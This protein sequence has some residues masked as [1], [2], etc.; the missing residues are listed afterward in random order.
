[1][2]RVRRTIQ[3]CG[4]SRSLAREPRPGRSGRPTRAPSHF[5]S[6]EAGANS[7]ADC[8]APAVRGT[9][10]VSARVPMPGEPAGG[11]ARAC[12]G[13]GRGRAWA[14]PAGAPLLGLRLVDRGI[15]LR[16]PSPAAPPG[17]RGPGPGGT[18]RV[19][20]G[21]GGR[22]AADESCWQRLPGL[23]AVRPTPKHW[24]PP[25]C[26]QRLTLAQCWRPFRAPHHSC[27]RLGRRRR[28]AG[29]LAPP[30]S[31][32]A[33]RRARALRERRRLWTRFHRPRARAG[34]LRFVRR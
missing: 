26:V 7:P 33:A 2:D 20:A 23:D 5:L 25:R 14:G 4:F 34:I 13:R 11:G 1:M 27:E 9:L 6:R 29:S 15:W 24:S 31:W 8:R 19:A 28:R 17:P 22:R 21:H 12:H 16:S 3:D 32:D 18:G 10:A 30:R